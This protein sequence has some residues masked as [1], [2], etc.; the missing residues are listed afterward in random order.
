MCCAGDI[1]DSLINMMPAL[2]LAQTMPLR[3]VAGVLS[4]GRS[5]RLRL[6]FA[7]PS[8]RRRQSIASASSAP[9]PC[10]GLTLMRK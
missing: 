8:T 10:A 1:G 5:T 7:Y 6:V 4:P 3:W 9:A 2:S